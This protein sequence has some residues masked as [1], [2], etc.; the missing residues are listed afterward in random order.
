MHG[1]PP[2]TTSERGL[3]T[4]VG[5]CAAILV[6]FLLHQARPVFAPLAFALLV[7]AIVWPVQRRLQVW[8]PKLV[9]LALSTLVTFLIVTVFVSI[10]AWGFGRVGRYLVSEAATFQSLYGQAAAWLEQHGIV[11]AG[12]W[13][14][15][16]NMGWVVRIFQELLSRV[17]QYPD[18]LAGRVDLRHPRAA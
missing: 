5:I 18:L 8:L 14:E 16:F 10:V 15:H 1:H 9:A 11:V 13:A 17:N 12:L 4:L 2:A 3:A 6:V 7:I